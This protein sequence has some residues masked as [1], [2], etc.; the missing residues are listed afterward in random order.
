MC[1]DLL[2]VLEGARLLPASSGWPRSALALGEAGASYHSFASAA[3]L[4]RTERPPFPKQCFINAQ[5]D[6]ARGDTDSNSGKHVL[7]TQLV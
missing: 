1:S 7:Q 6:E 3:A 4:G 2:P 5:G